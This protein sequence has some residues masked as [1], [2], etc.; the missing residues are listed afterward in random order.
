MDGCLRGTHPYMTAMLAAVSSN[1]SLRSQMLIWF[2]LIW[3][4]FFVCTSCFCCLFPAEAV[5]QESG[6]DE[7]TIP[8]LVVWL[9]L[10]SSL[11]SAWSEIWATCFVTCFWWGFIVSRKATSLF[12]NWKVPS[13]HAYSLITSCMALE[14]CIIA[15]TPDIFISDNLLIFLSFIAFSD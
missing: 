5:V 6:V 13:Y 11:K 10:G 14:T 9:L 4:D 2:D 15:L 3:F 12:L 1:V 8:L 7:L